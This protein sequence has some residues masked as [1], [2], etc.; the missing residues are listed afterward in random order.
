MVKIHPRLRV[1]NLRIPRS[2]LRLFVA[3]GPE[4]IPWYM[5][6]AVPTGWY[7]IVCRFIVTPDAGATTMMFCI[8]HRLCLRPVLYVEHRP[9]QAVTCC[10]VTFASL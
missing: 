4:R 2:T 5:S 9:D 7:I 6:S 8:N 10:A 3:V 1:L